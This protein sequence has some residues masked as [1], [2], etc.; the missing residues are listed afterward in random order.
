MSIIST[1]TNLLKGN[2]NMSTISK[3]DNLQPDLFFTVEDYRNIGKSYNGDKTMLK[4]NLY[5]TKEEYLAWVKEW[6]TEINRVSNQIRLD[7]KEHNQSSRAY[8]RKVARHLLEMRMNAKIASWKY[9][10]EKLAVAA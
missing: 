6:K 5:F 8:H 7:K 1:I 3:G 2:K 9:K 10:Q 4:L